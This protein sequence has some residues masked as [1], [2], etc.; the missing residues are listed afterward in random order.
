MSTAR[1]IQWVSTAPSGGEE[2]DLRVSFY[3]PFVVVQAQGYGIR[4]R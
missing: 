1:P 4:W 3:V 2:V